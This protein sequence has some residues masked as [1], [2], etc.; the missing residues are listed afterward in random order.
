MVDGEGYHCVRAVR[1]VW[2]GGGLGEWKLCVLD[3]VG[4][5]G[6]CWLDLDFRL[7]LGVS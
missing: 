2:G 1:L 4:C 7:P 6:C 3:W 5:D